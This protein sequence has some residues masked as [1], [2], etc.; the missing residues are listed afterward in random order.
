MNITV[1]STTSIIQ[2]LP[3]VIPMNV[4]IP[5]THYV[6][7]QVYIS[8]KPVSNV[9]QKHLFS[10]HVCRFMKQI[11]NFQTFFASVETFLTCEH[12]FVSVH[13]ALGIFSSNHI[14]PLTLYT[15]LPSSK[16]C[17]FHLKTP[18]KIRLVIFN[19]FLIVSKAHTQRQTINSFY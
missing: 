13:A 11:H 10:I 9:H 7:S 17:L 3:C 15:I 5:K 8:Y 18:Y 12:D 4:F 14:I 6:S 2:I 1:E 16:M 19:I